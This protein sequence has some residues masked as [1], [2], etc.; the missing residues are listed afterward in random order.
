MEVIDAFVENGNP[1]DAGKLFKTPND[2]LRYLW[3]KHTD[4]ADYFKNDCTD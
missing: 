1:E 2:I 4:F 3:F